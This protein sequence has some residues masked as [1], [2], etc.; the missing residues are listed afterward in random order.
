MVGRALDYEDLG[1]LQGEVAGT[2]VA[3]LPGLIKI[4]V[5]IKNVLGVAVKSPPPRVGMGRTFRGPDLNMIERR[6]GHDKFP[7]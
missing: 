6:L 1:D 3:E 2:A 7:P 4:A 5:L